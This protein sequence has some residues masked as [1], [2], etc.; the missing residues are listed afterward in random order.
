MSCGDFRLEARRVKASVGWAIAAERA[1]RMSWSAVL[2]AVGYQIFMEWVS[3]SEEGAGTGAE[4]VQKEAAEQ[5]S[6]DH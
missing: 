6:P 1:D 2:L 3:N 5:A 4:L